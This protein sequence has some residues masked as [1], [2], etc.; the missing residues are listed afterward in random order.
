MMPVLQNESR[1]PNDD[2]THTESK[3]DC[4]PAVRID[5]FN[6]TMASFPP[7]GSC[8][9]RISFPP[10]FYVVQPGVKVLAMPPSFSPRSIVAAIHVSDLACPRNY[11]N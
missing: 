6:L 2:E 7:S 10:P 8:I 3:P 11:P 9:R 5:A 4:V 1:T